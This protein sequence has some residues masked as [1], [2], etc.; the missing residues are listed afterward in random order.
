MKKKS[1]FIAIY[2]AG[3]FAAAAVLRFYHLSFFEFKYDQLSAILLGNQA[4]QAHFLVTHGMGSGVGF[5]NPPFFI[6]LMAALTY[7]TNNPYLL[8]AFFTVLNLIALLMAIWYFCAF[9]P[10]TYALLSATLLAFSPAFTIY[11]S[12]IW[13]QCSLPIILILFSIIFCRFIQE[14]KPVYFVILNLLAG[15][16]AQIHMSGFFLFLALLI[17]GFKYRLKIKKTHIF[18]IIGLLFIV[19]LP[20]IYHI[21]AEGGKGAVFAYAGKGKDIP[22]NIFRSHLWMSSFDFFRSYFKRDFFNVLWRSSGIWGLVLYPATF[23]IS[24]LFTVGF[25]LY[26][27]F[28][29]K[30]KRIFDKNNLSYPLPFQVSG[31]LVSIVTLGYLIF[32]VRTPLHYLIVL[33]PSHAVITAFCAWRLWKYKIIRVGLVISV[34]ATVFLMSAVLHFLNE[35]GGHP[36]AYGPSYK[37]LNDLGGKIKLL[38]QRGEFCPVLRLSLPKEGKFDEDAIRFILVKDYVC[39]DGVKSLPINLSLAWDTKSMRYVYALINGE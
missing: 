10:V 19:F 5:D 16:C 12:N 29:I 38:S 31:F 30:G 1:V 3:I 36:V 34:V 18:L 37:M 33:F 13:A 17:L 24:G 35:A 20:Y 9:M 26:V 15:I 8:T 6:Y 7:F 32:Q 25:I 4:R 39:K 22:W 23:I 21:F 11:S 28:L 27:K 14:E 2:L